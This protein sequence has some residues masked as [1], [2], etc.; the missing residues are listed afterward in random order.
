GTEA[1]GPASGTTS[2]GLMLRTPTTSSRSPPPYRTR[3]RQSVSELGWSRTSMTPAV[4]TPFRPVHGRTISS[5]SA[6]SEVRASAMAS[7]ERS[8]GQ[9]SRSHESTTF[10]SGSPRALELLEEPDVALDE[11]PDVRHAGAQQRHALDAHPEREARVAL[12]VVAD[13]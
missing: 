13:V 10:T 6:P 9:S 11:H 4:T 12:G 8:V 1:P 5:T 7:A 2:P 3:A